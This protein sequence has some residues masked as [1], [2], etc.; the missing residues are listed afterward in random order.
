MSIYLYFDYD[1]L[2]CRVET[3][4][5]RSYYEAEGYF[6]GSGF[7]PIQPLQ[8]IQDGSPLSEAKFK[9]LIASQIVTAKKAVQ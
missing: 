4:E 7:R 2:A 9:E 1:D 6:P 3:D 8:V 5:K